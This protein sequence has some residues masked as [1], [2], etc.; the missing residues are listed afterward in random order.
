MRTED[1]PTES[2]AEALRVERFGTMDELEKERY[3]TPQ[4]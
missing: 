3:G 4:G 1:E 2:V